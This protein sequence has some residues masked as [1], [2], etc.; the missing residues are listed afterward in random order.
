M[1]QIPQT[2]ENDPI[3]QVV[4][5]EQQVPQEDHE[6]TLR[7]STRK[8]DYNIGATND[9]KSFTQAMSSKESNLWY[10]AMIDEMDSMTSNQVWYL[11]ELPNSVKAIG[12]RCIFKTKKDS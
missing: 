3:D 5:E 9:P 11:V 4:D 7:R 8:S 2:V 10:N 6:A 1:I 12:C